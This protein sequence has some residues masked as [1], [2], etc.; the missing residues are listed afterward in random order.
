MTERRKNRACSPGAIY[1]LNA[2]SLVS[3]LHFTPS[4]SIH[5]SHLAAAFII[6]EV[7]WPK[8]C[9]TGFPPLHLFHFTA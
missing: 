5:L 7:K 3:P 6:E 8:A 1:K 9:R 2:F 4:P